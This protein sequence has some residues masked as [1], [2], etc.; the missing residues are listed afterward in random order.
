MK[1][2]FP[3]SEI[4]QEMI[5][6]VVAPHT[7]DKRMQVFKN[8]TVSYCG[9]ATDATNRSAMKAF[10]GVIHYRDWKNGGLQSKLIE[11]QQ[12]SHIAAQT[13]VRYIKRTLENHR[14]LT[15]CI[16][17]VGGK[18]NTMCG[19]LWRNVAGKKMVLKN[20]KLLWIIKSTN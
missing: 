10:P 12:L 18:W 7:V 20:S 19:G 6:S 9:I 17:F 14:L 4:A 8:I 5:N 2:I 15:K 13:A 11:V 3:D 1:T 16:A